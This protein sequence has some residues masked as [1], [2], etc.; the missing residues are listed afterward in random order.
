[1]ETN[2][3]NT[4]DYWKA[5]A[6]GRGKEIERL[7]RRVHKQREW[8]RQLKMRLTAHRVADIKHESEIARYRGL[9]VQNQK[10]IVAARQG[11]L[12]GIVLQPGED[13]LEAMA[14]ILQKTRTW[15]M[16]QHR[17]LTQLTTAAHRISNRFE[18]AEITE[19]YFLS[20]LQEL[21]L[22]LLSAQ[23]VL[24]GSL[25]YTTQELARKEQQ[26]K[27]YGKEVKGWVLKW[28]I[29]VIEKKGPVRK[30]QLQAIREQTAK[31]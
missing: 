28:L 11:A 14:L 8:M 16:E 2:Y 17:A 27:D 13:R 23:D 26:A 20:E 6:L 10:L 9:E 15:S 3:F 30:K 31:L 29:E 19:D 12:H 1:M 25:S 5:L 7:Q 18:G 4:I 22:A 24:Q 21:A